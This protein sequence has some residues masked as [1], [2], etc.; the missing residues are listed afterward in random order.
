LDD[1]PACEVLERDDYSQPEDPGIMQDGA[2]AY[3]ERSNHKEDEAEDMDLDH[4]LIQTFQHDD[5][6]YGTESPPLGKFRARRRPV[7][8][9]FG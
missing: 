9:K 5:L 2:R 1:D 3:G 8:S 4:A 7:F 6:H